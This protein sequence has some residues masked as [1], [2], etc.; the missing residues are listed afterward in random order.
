MYDSPP[1]QGVHRELSLLLRLQDIDSHLAEVESQLRLVPAQL[2]RLTERVEHAENELRDA[3]REIEGLD[4]QRR[5]TEAEVEDAEQKLRKYQGQL[6]EVR[7]NEQYQ[8]LLHEINSLKDKVSG[9]EDEVL[10]SMEAT[11][12]GRERQRRLRERLAEEK[13]ETSVEKARIEREAQ[14]LRRHGA[15][16]HRRR[17]EIMS[18]LPEELVA[19]YERIRKGK[20]GVAIATVH[21]ET[22][23]VCHGFIPPQHIA[24]VKKAAEVFYCH[25]CGRIL[26]WENKATP[27]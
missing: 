5:S 6:A 22:C 21:G 9:W 7:T 14:E 10:E 13:R 12:E 26:V 17:T 18:G 8:A 19:A 3:Q 23:S 27:E 25:N 11:D 20:G 16:W 15:D 24:E 1:A 2:E 4:K